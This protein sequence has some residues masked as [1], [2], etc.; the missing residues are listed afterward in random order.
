MSRADYAHWNE[1]ADIIWWQEEGRHVET[2]D[3]HYDPDD[4]LDS[5]YSAADAFAEDIAEYDDSQL[6]KLIADAD[7]RKRWPKAMPVIEAE[8]QYR[9]LDPIGKGC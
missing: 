4:Y 8:M 7:Y 5:G 6:F 1:E 2:A 9:G 3:D